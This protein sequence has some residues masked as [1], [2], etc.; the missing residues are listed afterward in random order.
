[1]DAAA[2]IVAAGNGVRV[3]G[4]IPKQYRLL[5]G[6]PVLTRTLASFLDHPR[7]DRVV[8]VIAAADRP[9]YAV[10]ASAFEGHVKLTEPVIGGISRQASVRAGLESL[11]AGETETVLVHDGVRPFASAALISATLDGLV[12]MDGAIAAL[13]VSETL[14]RTVDGMVS[15]T[16]DRAGM[17]SAQTPQAFRFATLLGAHRMAATVLDRNFTD[18]AALLEWQ[19]RSVAIVP[20]ELDNIKIT[21]P[22]DFSRAERILATPLRSDI[23]T[24]IGYDVHAFTEGDHVMLGGVRIPHSMGVLAHSDGDVAL[25]A[26]TDAL[27]GALADG[28]IGTHFPPSDPAWRGASSDRFLTH[29]AGLVRRQGGAIANLDI[30]IVAETPRVGAHREAMQRA[31]AEAAGLD[32]ARVSI[33]A[34]T[35]ER[36][37][38]LGRREG[39][40]AFAIATVAFPAFRANS[41]AS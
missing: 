30:T 12:D 29:A 10:A 14:K 13:P 1:M 20:G 34:T 27:L 11:A 26:A 37:G 22:G 33:K 41:S 36:L 18:D 8:P 40:A 19:G 28:D 31:I 38:F 21:L 7:I 25:H 15:G 2:I 17:F 23:R 6:T 16:V 9:L 3:G 32:A 24:G 4:E 5:S 35:S 39:L